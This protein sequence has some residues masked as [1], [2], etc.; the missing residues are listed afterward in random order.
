M[1]LCIAFLVIGSILIAI[2]G[3]PVIAIRNRGVME[4]DF[5]AGGVVGAALSFLGVV[6]GLTALYG[7]AA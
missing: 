2:F 1:I 4:Y 3:S 5:S 7:G 6:S